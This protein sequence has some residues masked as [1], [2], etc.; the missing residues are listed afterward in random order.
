MT[1]PLQ[2]IVV[3][4]LFSAVIAFVCQKSGASILQ[5]DGS[6]HIGM[7]I[8]MI[9]IAASHRKLE[10]EG[11]AGSNIP[12]IKCLP[13]IA[14]NSMGHRR[15]VLPGDCRTRSNRQRRRAKAEAAI[16]IIHDQHHLCKAGQ[17]CGLWRWCHHSGRV[18][19]SGHGR[20]RRRCSC[21]TG[22]RSTPA[23]SE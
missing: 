6:A 12:T 1:S 5:I 19:Y 10:G 18:R 14:G 13:I 8:A 3:H 22:S 17:R 9:G 23:G 21:G 2:K 16:A 11:A 7:D 20:Y 4:P 15:H